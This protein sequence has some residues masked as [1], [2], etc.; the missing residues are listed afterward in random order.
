MNVGKR[1]GG[2]AKE[3]PPKTRRDVSRLVLFFV[4][5]FTG[6]NPWHHAT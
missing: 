4:D 2:S 5:H 6:R 3:P 1:K